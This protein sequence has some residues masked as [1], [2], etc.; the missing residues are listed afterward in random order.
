VAIQTPGHRNSI[1]ATQKFLKPALSS[2]RNP[3]YDDRMVLVLRQ[4]G[5]DVDVREL[6]VQSESYDASHGATSSRPGPDG[7]KL[8]ATR[9]DTRDG[10]TVAGDKDT[11][12]HKFIMPSMS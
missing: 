7:S 12:D 2:D 8:S 6:V 5:A 4:F 11:T 1:T 10:V 9:T 3:L